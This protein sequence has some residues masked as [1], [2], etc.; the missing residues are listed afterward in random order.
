MSVLYKI[1]S[2]I[3]KTKDGKMQSESKKI[4]AAVR[5]FDA[6][7]DAA[8]LGRPALCMILG[9]SRTTLWRLEQAGVLPAPRKPL[10]GGRNYWTAGDVRRFLAE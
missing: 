5:H 1:G 10:G 7:P 8:R 2:S 9:K 6:L 3:T 4:P